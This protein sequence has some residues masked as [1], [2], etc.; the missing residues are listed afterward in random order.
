MINV[1][2]WIAVIVCPLIASFKI[3]LQY[4]YSGSI[5]ERLDNARGFRNDYTGGVVGFIIGFI[6]S[7]TYL[8]VK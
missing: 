6:V 1:L 4:N 8:I 3:Y 2:S 5:T 7:L